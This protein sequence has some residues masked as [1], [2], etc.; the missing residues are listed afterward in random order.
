MVRVTIAADIVKAIAATGID[1]FFNVQAVS[2]AAPVRR[3]SIRGVRSTAVVI[4]PTTTVTDLRVPFLGAVTFH[5]RSVVAL[6]NL[7]FLHPIL[8]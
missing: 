3:V 2:K 7:M 4:A 5:V 6:W 1:V 8:R